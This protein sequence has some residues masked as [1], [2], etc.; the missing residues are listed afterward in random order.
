MFS[1]YQFTIVGERIQW[2]AV[3]E[4]VAVLDLTLRQINSLKNKWQ[5]C[6]GPYLIIAS[7]HLI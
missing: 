1:Y 4:S 3:S 7:K 5:G 2:V 6:K